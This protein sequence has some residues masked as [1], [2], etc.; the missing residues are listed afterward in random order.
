[1]QDLIIGSRL[2]GRYELLERLGSGA[3]ARVYRARQLP[4]D[5]DVAI[6]VLRADVAG[7]SVDVVRA[8]FKRE[9]KQ[10]ARLSHP[11]VVK[12]FDYDV[13][14][15]GTAYLVL[16][17]LHGCTLHS[18]LTREPQAAGFVRARHAELPEEER[19][20]VLGRW[21]AFR[22]LATT[23][24]DEAELESEDLKAAIDSL[25]PIDAARIV[26]RVEYVLRRRTRASEHEA[27]LARLLAEPLP[28]ELRV[29]LLV[30]YGS[31]I[32]ERAPE[33]AERVLEKA[34][35]ITEVPN[36]VRGTALM[37]AA[38]MCLFTG[39]TQPAKSR[40]RE[41]LRILGLGSI[42]ARKVWTN[43]GIASMYDGDLDQAK[44]L[45]ELAVAENRLLRPMRGLGIALLNLA[46]YHTAVV[47]LDA[48]RD[49]TREARA[50]FIAVDEP[51]YADFAL[52]QQSVVELDAGNL[53]DAGRLLRV[54]LELPVHRGPL[55]RVPFALTYLGV[56]ALLCGDDAAARDYLAE[57]LEVF[58][59][60]VGARQRAQTAIFCALAIAESDPRGASRWL[61]EA[62]ALLEV[63]PDARL[64]D[65]V[66]LSRVGLTLGAEPRKTR[67]AVDALPDRAWST[68]AELRFVGRILR[69]RLETSEA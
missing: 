40:L 35:S 30:A 57:A 2:G 66:A 50:V 28:S 49:A 47:E 42:W 22:A 31:A 20:A 56:H 7:M 6:K 63:A 36:N 69:R 61:D 25:E 26:A 9:A 64:G 32:R 54:F 48:A 12:L 3:T 45:F 17:R 46:T 62:T 68:S 38:T 67:E 10:L 52:A 44:E 53:V 33:Q 11:N 19:S 39:P 1:M 55:V 60:S 34:C 65:V 24:Y 51:A 5:R 58:S 41:A 37:V 29:R 16:E 21:R 4:F 23:T 13:L 8:R 18:R 15:N 14:D 59:A 43:M 27:R